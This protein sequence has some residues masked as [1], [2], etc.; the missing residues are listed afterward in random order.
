MH[1][2][3]LPDE[4]FYNLGA[5]KPADRRILWRLGTSSD[6]FESSKI[7]KSCELVIH[8]SGQYKMRWRIDFEAQD[9]RRDNI[10]RHVF[11]LLHF[12]FFGRSGR[13][14]P[15]LGCSWLVFLPVY[16]PD[17]LLHG[18][19]EQQLVLGVDLQSIL[20]HDLLGQQQL[21]VGLVERPQFVPEVERVGVVSQELAD[22][23]VHG[24]AGQAE[25]GE[26]TGAQSAKTN[27]NN[28]L[29]SRK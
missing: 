9:S 21:W 1:T 10:C 28:K 2:N 29:L 3:S 27:S 23:H 15:G 16:L 6:G 25:Q 22:D 12:S 7:E 11:L 14:L 26:V 18:A 8:V 4:P 24:P 20:Q 17:E 19:V 5:P 13:S